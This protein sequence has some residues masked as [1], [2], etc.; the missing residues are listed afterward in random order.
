MLGSHP[1]VGL[2][3]LVTPVVA[4]VASGATVGDIRAL[5]GGVSAQVIAFE[6]EHPDSP[7]Q[8]L[9]LRRHGETDYANNPNIAAD[10]YRLLQIL[11]AVGV[12]A[13]V[14]IY[15]DTS[16][17]LLPTPYLV[18]TYI[19]GETQLAPIHVT[20]FVKHMAEQLVNIHTRDYSKH[21][22]SFLPEQTA[23]LTDKIQN[24]P[25][26]LDDSLSENLIRDALESYGIPRPLN[27]PML[28]HGDYWQGNLLWRDDKI[29]AVIDWEDAAVGDPVADLANARLEILWAF[30]SRVMRAFT[31]RYQSLNPLDYTHL[32]LWDLYAAL[33]PASK[34]DSWGLDPQTAR[35]MR[36]RHKEFVSKA[37]QN[38][39]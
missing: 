10:E 37:L 34:L 4:R 21:D 20:R 31:Q 39:V 8:K 27:H 28:L 24:R 30:G 22:L 13:P 16:R 26:I 35:K 23:R 5:T 6:I 3:D 11:N 1:E 9:V 19:E 36:R 17:E 14:P 7:R 2:P 15:L 18:V 29:A 25:A 32:P 33:R 12:P 38:H